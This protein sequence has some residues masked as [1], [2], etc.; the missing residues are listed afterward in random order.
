ML[1]EFLAT[2]NSMSAI[3]ITRIDQ[4]PAKSNKAEA[5][6]TTFSSGKNVAQPGIGAGAYVW[7]RGLS[8]LAVIGIHVLSSLPI[9]IFSWPEGQIILAMID[10]SFRW[11]VPF[12]VLVSAF[13]LSQ[14]YKNEQPGLFE[15][16]ISQFKKLIPAYVVASA[17][18]YL[19]LWLVPQWG[20]GGRPA[21]FLDLILHGSADYHLYFVWL[22]TQLY[23]LFPVFAWLKRRVPAPLLLGAALVWQL[24]WYWWLGTPVDS[25]LRLK[26]STDQ[27]QY[28]QWFSWIW[29]FMVGLYGESI[30]VWLEKKARAGW[31]LLLGVL[32][33]YGWCV[34][35]AVQGMRTGMDPLM[36]NR[37]T[38]I[39]VL[40]FAT[41]TC[42]AFLWSARRLATVAKPVWLWFLH[43]LGSVSY[44][45]YLWHTVV[46][47][48][49]FTWILVFPK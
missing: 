16:I 34:Y 29:Y 30:L 26:Y 25:E 37:F 5:S 23:L 14:K 47:R 24:Y 43:W 40:V 33:S 32:A 13:G 38:K 28:R 4:K 11:C 44:P 22:V 31:A 15:V 9:R 12:Y 45:L 27:A 21:P 6:K 46:L 18:I 17:G 10:Q 49:I 42:F 36:A 19:I 20:G 39:P 2:L 1:T 7:L 41:I 8:V 35:Y 3:L 48:A